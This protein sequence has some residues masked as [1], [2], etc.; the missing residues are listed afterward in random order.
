MIRKIRRKFL[1]GFL[2]LGLLASA[3]L[4]PVCAQA[5]DF[6]VLFGNLQFPK[7]KV[8]VVGGPLLF[9]DPN[10]EGADENEFKFLPY[11]DLSLGETFFFNLQN[12]LG[13]NF[14]NG[15]VTAGISMGYYRSREEEDSRFLKGLG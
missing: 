14:F 2:F 3:S 9:S 15:D 10:Y 8:R 4:N 7:E 11:F 1:K 6:W 13:L 5:D 12:G